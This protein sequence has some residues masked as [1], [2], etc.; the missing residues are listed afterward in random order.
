MMKIFTLL[1]C[2]AFLSACASTPKKPEV[3]TSEINCD[4]IAVQGK[5]SVPNFKAELIQ[6]N[7]SIAKLE[8][9]QKREEHTLHA[10]KEAVWSCEPAWAGEHCRGVEGKKLNAVNERIDRNNQQ[11]K[12]LG[13]NKRVYECLIERYQKVQ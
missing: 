10:V 9:N 12:Q 4:D 5:V 11:L 3:I 2:I 8:E 7:Q 1:L 13:T 6:I